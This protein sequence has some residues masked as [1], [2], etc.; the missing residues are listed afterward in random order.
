MKST[1]H[2]FAC[3]LFGCTAPSDSPPSPRQTDSADG[4]AGEAFTSESVRAA[5]EPVG[6][7]VPRGVGHDASIT[8]VWLDHRATAALSL[9]ADGGVRLWPTLPRA[10]ADSAA[11]VPIRVPIREPASL[12][13][14]RAGDQA[15]VIGAIDTAQSARVIAIELDDA[16]QPR[17]RERFT[18]PPHDPLLELHVLDGGERVLALGVDHRLRLYDG[19]GKRLNEL[20]KYGVSPWQL[21]LAGPAE[22]PVFALVL[23]GPTRLQRFTITDDRLVELGEPHA[24]IMDRGPNQNDLAL[25]PSGRVAALL[26]RPKHRTNQWSLELHDLD[27][28]EVRV[29]WGEVETSLRPRLYI[30]DDARALLED[31]SGAGFWIDLSA[32]VIMPAP[33]ELP[34]ALEQLPPESHVIPRREQLPSSSVASRRSTSVVAGLRVAPLGSALVFDPLDADR[35]H[36][37]EQRLVSVTDLALDRAGGQLAMVMTDGQVVVETLGEDRRHAVVGCTTDPVRALEFTDPDHLLLLGEA[38][39]QICEWVAGKVV[40]EVELPSHEY[41]KIRPTEPGAGQL[42]VVT[43]FGHGSHQHQIS[44]LSFADNRSSALESVP[45]SEFSSWPEIDT[46]GRSLALDH[47]GRHYAHPKADPRAFEITAADGE[48]RIV[49]IAENKIDIE[50]LEP[51]ADGRRVAVVHTPHVESNDYAYEYSYYSYDPP[52]T[53]SV[54]SVADDIPELLWSTPA[55]RSM[56][57]AWSADGSRL[58]LDLGQGVRVV[59]AE[60]ELVFE[61]LQHDLEIE[62]HPDVPEPPQVPEPPTVDPPACPDEGEAGGC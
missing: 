39:V 17:V 57:M 10:Q 48:P 4:E 25:L 15:F 8:E 6:V 22:A 40:S 42:G 26:R 50:K 43:Q 58:A 55:D 31:G 2:L 9:D 51:S 44:R 1:R 23:A 49:T 35:H 53:L 52:R 14:A 5:S 27:S 30:I 34:A 18:I 36:R 24:F 13:L 21:R 59:T 54:W 28:G 3:V 32:G 29:M 20:S 41:A 12:S 62:E 19:H 16:G 47:T 60:G 33:F 11:V 7:A 56:H 38:R 61:R 45:K 46:D 37:V